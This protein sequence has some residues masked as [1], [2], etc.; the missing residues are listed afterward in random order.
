MEMIRLT[1]APALPH[2]DWVIINLSNI[3]LVIV[4]GPQA[5]F[6]ALFAAFDAHCKR[7][8]ALTGAIEHVKIGK[9]G[10]CLFT[11][12]VCRIL[13]AKAVFDTTLYGCSTVNVY[14]N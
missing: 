10:V 4:I 11:D 14:L 8:N 6:N 13:E 2:Q 1:G 3:S 12:C 5:S 7:R 9:Y